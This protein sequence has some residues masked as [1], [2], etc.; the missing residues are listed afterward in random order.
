M[1]LQVLYRFRF[2]DE[3]NKGTRIK[4]TIGI[5]TDFIAI[6]ANGDMHADDADR[7]DERGFYIE[8]L[9]HSER[10]PDSYRD[11]VEESQRKRFLRTSKWN[12]Y[13]EVACG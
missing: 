10:S 7:L 5:F 9:F 3:V 8:R 1:V 2:R 11:E 6:P 4:G 12:T 13:L